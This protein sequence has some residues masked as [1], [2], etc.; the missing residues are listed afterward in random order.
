MPK[1]PRKVISLF[2]GAGGLD[3]GFEAAGYETAVAVEM[4]DMCVQT[5]RHNRKWPVIHSD[6]HSVSSEAILEVSKLKKYEASLLIG[7]PPCQPFS[8]SGFWATGESKRLKDPRASTLDEYLRILEDTL[9]EAFLLE[10]VAGIAYKGKAEGLEYL[11]DRIATINGKNKTNY[12][13][14]TMRLNAAATFYINSF[15]IDYSSCAHYFILMNTKVVLWVSWL[16]TVG[17]SFATGYWV[18][19]F[20][21]RAIEAP[22]ANKNTGAGEKQRSAN[23]ED[24]TEANIF[25]GLENGLSTQAGEFSQLS[26]GPSGPLEQLSLPSDWRRAELQAELLSPEEAIE[27]AEAVLTLPA[28]P[29][30]DR[31]LSV[32]LKRM[33]LTQPVAAMGLVDRIGSVS[34]GESAR[35]GILE[36]WGKTNPGAALSWLESNRGSIPGRLQSNRFEA[37]INGYAE[38]NPSEAFTYVTALPESSQAEMYRKRRLVESVIAS[39]VESG[40]IKEALNSLKTLPDG[41]VRQEAME[42]FYS[43]WA[44]IDPAGAASHFLE[45]REEGS[46][47]VAAGMVRAWAEIDPQ[48]ASEF[49][50]SLETTD[51][52]FEVAISSLIERWSRFDLEGPAQWLNEL[53]PSPEIDRAV[54][55]FSVR[56]SREDPAGAMS[57]A[58]SISAENTRSR[59]MQRVAGSWKAS[60]PAGLE[61]YLQQSELDEETR[62]SMRNASDSW[63]SR[64]NRD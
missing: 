34:T 40:Q 23:W 5:L 11:L 51:P 21:D 8:K 39:Q 27:W 3:L 12:R 9:P 4:D 18:T 53:P 47:R 13:V 24:P 62:N 22:S 44:E 32:I 61:A 64:W 33:A 59:V 35:L 63:R 30:R 50:S 60:D 52:A 58:E 55:V 36:S 17:L 42:E 15:P 48:A 6:V 38:A 37:W 43:E 7:G 56:A 1:R 31:L 29:N 49:V 54:S 10:N 14:E 20:T 16:G 46:E 2:T 25:D 19:G 57:W 41:R 26:S 28:G 45:S